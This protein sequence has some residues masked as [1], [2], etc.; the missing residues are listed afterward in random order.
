M[1]N[2]D[3]QDDK[4]RREAFERHLNEA[5]QIVRSWPEWKRNVLGAPRSDSSHSMA[6]H[7]T[8]RTKREG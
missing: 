1:A 3:H 2:D 7:S 6:V 5:S 8:S 4:A